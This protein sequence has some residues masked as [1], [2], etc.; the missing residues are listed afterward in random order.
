MRTSAR[1]GIIVF[2]VRSENR[3]CTPPKKVKNVSLIQT[4]LYYRFPIKLKNEG[5]VPVHELVNK[6]LWRFD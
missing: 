1:G 3:R 2:L 4:E 6:Y 5:I